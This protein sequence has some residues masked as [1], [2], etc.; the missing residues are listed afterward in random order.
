MKKFIQF[1]AKFF[2]FP[3]EKNL[4]QKKPVL[5][6]HIKL[7][8]LVTEI[9][10]KVGGSVFSKGKKGNQL[11]SK[12]SGGGSQAQS[13]IYGNEFTDFTWSGCMAQELDIRGF[14]MPDGS[15]QRTLR[16]RNIR[17]STT[18][19]AKA[20]QSLLD[21]DRSAWASMAKSY[22][23][24][25]K[26]GETKT[27]SG[28]AFYVA[29]NSTLVNIGLSPVARPGCFWIQVID[30]VAQET[31]MC[32]YCQGSIQYCYYIGSEEDE[33]ADAERSIVSPRF[34]L[35]GPDGY[36]V[37]TASRPQSKGRASVQN[38]KLVAVIQKTDTYQNFIVN[39]MLNR[40]FGANIYD[41]NIQ[42]N[43]MLVNAGAAYTPVFNNF[44]ALSSPATGSKIKYTIKADQFSF[45]V[46]GTTLAFG[47][48]PIGAPTVKTI[49]IL[50]LTLPV[51]SEYS[52]VLSGADAAKYS[53]VYGALSDP[54]ALTGNTIDKYGNLLPIPLQITFTPTGESTFT[55]LITITCGSE[56]LTIPLTGSGT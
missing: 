38:T 26:L 2:Y 34:D 27:K 43:C 24:K 39:L 56:V 10:G 48:C 12:R 54:L 41:T 20:W 11:K 40:F 6:A 45:E 22:P 25:N 4:L 49:L 31:Q 37:I 9:S 35:G 3:S 30:P 14:V 8:A 32:W 53:L 51:G 21:S 23:S 52:I 15:Y 16:V 28:Y 50:G 1:L 7:S 42:L 5:K 47:L 19:V 29:I 13:M 33:G 18:Q 46:S 17:K 36:M 44:S 55:A